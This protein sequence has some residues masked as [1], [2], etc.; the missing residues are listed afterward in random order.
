MTLLSWSVIEYGPKY[1]AIGEYNHIKD[2]IKWGTDYL[3]LTFNSS[4]ST[5]SKMY[6]QVT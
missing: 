5:I 3:L 4:A 1:E 2:I 6:S